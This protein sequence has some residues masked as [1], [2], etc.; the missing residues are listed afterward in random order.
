[1]NGCSGFLPVSEEDTN[2]HSYYNVVSKK[3]N[4]SHV[5]NFF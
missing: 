3:I 5:F 4:E 2:T 1:M